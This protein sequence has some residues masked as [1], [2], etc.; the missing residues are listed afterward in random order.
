MCMWWVVCYKKSMMIH[1]CMLHYLCRYQYQ[2]LLRN[3]TV[4][5]N[6]KQTIVETF[7]SIA[8][9]LIWGDQNDSRVFE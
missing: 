7:R 2:V 3:P 1:P 8:E 6:N 9:I 5:D 4:S